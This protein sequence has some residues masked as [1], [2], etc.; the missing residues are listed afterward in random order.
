MKQALIGYLLLFLGVVAVDQSS[1]WH[2]EKAYLE[3]SDSQETNRYRASH[4]LVWSAGVSPMRREELQMKGQDATTLPAETP[5]WVDFNTTYLRNEGAVWGIFSNLPDTFRLGLFYSVTVI[6]VFGALWLFRGTPIS[7]KIYRTAL[8]FILAGAIGNFIDR[9]MLT[10][11]IDWIHFHWKIFG[12]EY[13]FPVFNVADISINIGLG[14]VIVDLIRS[15]IL[16]R[17]VASL[18]TSSP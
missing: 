4:D 6:A 5:H 14:L 13:S 15:E 8:V 2:S 9:L 10:Y 18:S 17:R 12:W 11:V 1:K 3:H 7:N 16:A